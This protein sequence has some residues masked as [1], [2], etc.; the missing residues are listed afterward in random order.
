LP[1]GLTADAIVCQILE[2]NS[3][4]TIAPNETDGVCE[5]LSV[6]A[7]M[8]LDD[9]V[10]PFQKYTSIGRLQLFLKVFVPLASTRCPDPASSE[11]ADQRVQE[12][13]SPLYLP[14][15]APFGKSGMLMGWR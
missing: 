8:A 5:T 9:N 13:A 6:G 3:W 4:S 14:K 10:T 2:C 7:S 12:L 11:G 1:R 15:A